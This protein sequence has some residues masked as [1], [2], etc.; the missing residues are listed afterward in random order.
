[1]R[2]CAA[3]ALLAGAALTLAA[4][5][6]FGPLEPPPGPAVGATPTAS[7]APGSPPPPALGPGGPGAS[8]AAGPNSTEVAQKN[9]FDAYGNPVAP[10]GAK[11]SFPLD[12]LLQ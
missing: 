7:A 9:G 8:G 12:F 3:A 11:K 1:M 2:A 5:G 6:R 4:C 10:P